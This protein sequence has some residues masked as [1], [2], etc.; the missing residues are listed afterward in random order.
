MSSIFLN[1]V[2]P[3][4]TIAF[5]NDTPVKNMYTSFMLLKDNE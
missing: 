5:D 4:F 3:A 2:S 1:D